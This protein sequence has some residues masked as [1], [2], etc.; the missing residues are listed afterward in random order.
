MLFI[1]GMTVDTIWEK[2]PFGISKID[3]SIKNQEKAIANTEHR[4]GSIRLR[5]KKNACQP[6]INSTILIM[7]IEFFHPFVNQQA[8]FRRT[9]NGMGILRRRNFQVDHI[10][11][12]HNRLLTVV[13][14]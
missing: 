12:N 6:S 3:N 9:E 1:K 13:S 10:Q 4:E 5:R 8:V 2:P 14:V 7:G 11:I